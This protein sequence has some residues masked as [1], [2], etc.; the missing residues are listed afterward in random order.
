MPY[1]EK[2]ERIESAF[3]HLQNIENIL[4]VP[5]NET[6]PLEILQSVHSP[7]LIEHLQRISAWISTQEYQNPELPPLYHYPYIFPVRSDMHNRLAKSVESQGCF[8]FDTYA[9]IGSGTWQAAL[10]SASL[11]WQGAGIIRTG[12]KLVY[13]LCRPPGHHAGYDAIGGY[14]YLNNAAIAA[15]RLLPTGAGA[16]LDIDYHHGNGTQQIFWQNNQLLYVSLHADPSFEYP[17]FSGFVSETGGESAAG[18]N[19]NLPL[20]SG[21]EDELY[22]ETLS[23]A[24]ERISTFPA[25][26]LVLSAGFDTCAADQSTSFLL[27]DDV[28]EEIGR[29]IAATGLPV[30]VVHEGGYATEKNGELAA[31]LLKGLRAKGGG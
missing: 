2:P 26:W 7:R 27:S 14:C 9:P 16:I 21:C 18:C 8:A 30:L 19:L 24:L 4:T 17:Y 10:A 6:V 25:H 3:V 20:L 1:L 12:G 22:L 15:S 29:R 31:R 11:A 28:Y 5:P 23:V 13:A